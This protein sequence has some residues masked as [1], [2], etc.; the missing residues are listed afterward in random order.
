[1]A[2]LARI[3]EDGSKQDLG[4]HLNEVGTSAKRLI[5]RKNFDFQ[6][7]TDDDLARVAYIL[8]AAHDFGKGTLY[9]QKYIWPDFD[10]PSAKKKRHSSLSAFFAYFALREDGFEPKTALIGW[11]VV[12]RHHGSLTTLYGADGEIARKADDPDHK[13]LLEDQAVSIREGPIESLQETYDNLEDLP[14][15]E[16]FITGITTGRLFEEVH[17]QRFR[18]EIRDQTESYYLTLLLYSVLTDADKMSSAGVDFQ[19]WPS[20]GLDTITNID[21]SAV[22]KYKKEKLTVDSKLDEQREQAAQFV[23]SA[24]GK[25]ED[26]N[27]FSL[28]MPTGSGKTLTALQVALSRRSASAN[29]RP[30]RIFYSVPFLSIID[31]NHGVFRNVLET[32]GINP[33]PSTLLRHDHTSTGYANEESDETNGNHRNPDQALLLTE[34]WNSELV[35]TTFVQFF[36]T[37]V[38]NKNANARRFHKL[39]NSIILL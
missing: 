1:M 34:G 2:L 8:G 19:D 26:T 32:A 37:L 11:Y 18:H 6:H 5:E 21:S 35:T 15:V 33:K 24:V 9:F 4:D 39:S 3:T 38:T 27:L 13:S 29:D 14:S 7:L 23:D 22:Q 10:S 20:V 36:E 17:R 28:T 25:L 16:E 31:Q 30:P 12:Q